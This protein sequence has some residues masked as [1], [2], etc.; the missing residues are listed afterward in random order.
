MYRSFALRRT[1]PL[2]LLA[3]VALCMA[4]PTTGRAQS[5]MTEV[6]PERMT[7]ILTS[8]GLEATAM[9][10][11]PDGAQGPLRVELG[12]YGVYLFLLNKNTDGQLYV[13]FKGK[14]KT[15]LMNKWNRDH[16]FSR[17]YRD[18]DGDAVLEA[19]LD[20]AGGVTEE[21]IKAWVRLFRDMTMDYAA[22]VDS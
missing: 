7:T 18:D 9:P 15:D 2:R 11:G 16:R 10:E 21:A 22:Y 12:G 6:S 13:V 17:A 19:D 3:A 1:A 20:F 8:M 14:V 4:V 5:V